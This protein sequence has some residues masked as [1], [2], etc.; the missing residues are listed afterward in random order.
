MDWQNRC[1]LTCLRHRRHPSLII[2]VVQLIEP[3]AHERHE[4]QI[5]TGNQNIDAVAIGI[6]QQGIRGEAT[7]APNLGHLVSADGDLELL[8]PPIAACFAHLLS[9][10]ND[11]GIAFCNVCD[12]FFLESRC[13]IVRCST[14]VPGGMEAWRLLQTQLPNRVAVGVLERSTF[15]QRNQALRYL[16]EQVAVLVLN[17]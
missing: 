17:G 3:C 1:I 7:L 6:K 4:R 16:K 14:D 11:F 9:V 5:D 13:F 8:R 15:G 12:S 10:H 2:I